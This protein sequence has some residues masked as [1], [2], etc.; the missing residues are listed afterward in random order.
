M[1][2]SLLLL[3]AANLAGL[4]ALVV[5]AGC[6]NVPLRQSTLATESEPLVGEPGPG[7]EG[8]V[9]VQ[10][11]AP[12]HPWDL[13][14]AGIAGKVDLNLLIDETG[15]VIDAQVTGSTDAEFEESALAAVRKWTFKPA[16]RDGVPVRTR[17]RLPITFAFTD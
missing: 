16:S 6:T 14:R 10:R 15:R 11:I 17:A 4:G 13:R 3:R 2:T 8:P 1:K 7:Y 9:P 5:F 12:D